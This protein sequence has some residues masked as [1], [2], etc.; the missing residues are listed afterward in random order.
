MGLRGGISN[1]T[2]PNGSNSACKALPRRLGGW[3]ASASTVCKISRTSCSMDR[4]FSAALIL[5]RRFSP[6]SMLRTVM[7]ATTRPPSRI[8]GCSIIGSDCVAITPL[9]V[10]FDM[11][12]VQNS[13]EAF[14]SVGWCSLGVGPRGRESPV[15][16]SWHFP[17]ARLDG[18][19][20]NDGQA[21]WR[22]CTG[23]AG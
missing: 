20:L 3:L 8:L 2:S 1:V 12:S 23:S 9:R 18:S 16:S 22:S 15:P 19:I 14:G 4:S 10:P 11:A 7:L 17:I 5:S 13:R 21:V 6:S